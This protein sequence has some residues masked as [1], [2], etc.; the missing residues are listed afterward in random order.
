MAQAIL[1]IES[2]TSIKL[3]YDLLYM[4][5]TW[6]SYVHMVTGLGH[7]MLNLES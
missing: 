7:S 1:C 5:E 6:R 4:V 3:N 2:P